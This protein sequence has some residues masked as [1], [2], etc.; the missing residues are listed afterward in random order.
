MPAGKLDLQLEQTNKAT[1][2]LRNELV[3]RYRYLGYLPLPGAQLRYF[4]Q[5]QCGT[6][7]LLSF[8]AAAW[9]TDPRDRYIGW[10]P[11]TRK[12]N[13]HLV[14]E[15]S[16]FLGL[17]RV[18]SRNLAS[19]VP[20]MANRQ[21]ADDWQSRYNYRPVLL[22]TFVEERFKGTSYKAAGWIQ[23]GKTQGR[24]KKD[25][26]TPKTPACENRMVVSSGQ[27]LPSPSAGGRPASEEQAFIE[28]TPE[29]RA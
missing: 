13:I 18:Y 15:N 26:H 12:K 5:S 17:P 6:V 7:T 29:Q 27:G 28:L 10:V 25:V 24:G 1:L 23:V 20:A 9:K 14:A 21:L 11:A 8:S 2:P 19:R 16:R 22:E 4:V 3:D